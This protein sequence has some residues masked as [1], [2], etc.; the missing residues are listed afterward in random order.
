M[1]DFNP[2]EPQM[3]QTV[4]LTRIGSGIHWPVQGLPS[5]QMCSSCNGYQALKDF[6]GLK[7]GGLKLYKTCNNCRQKKKRRPVWR[8]D[9][10]HPNVTAEER[11]EHLNVTAER[12]ITTDFDSSDFDALAEY[13]GDSEY[14]EWLKKVIGSRERGDVLWGLSDC[15]TVFLK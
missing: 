5:T 13:Y 6:R 1:W 3:H 7:Q 15:L 14:D 11:R 10:K 8:K 2:A 4:H 9:V 12:N